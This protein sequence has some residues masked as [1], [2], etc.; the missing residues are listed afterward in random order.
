M[1]KP[2]LN[3]DLGEGTNNEALIMPLINSCSIACTGHVG[4]KHSMENAIV[5]AKQY[6]VHAGAHPSYPDPENFGRV[7]LEIS[8]KDLIGSI[9]QQ[10]KMLDSLLEKHNIPLNHIKAHGAL[11]NETAVNSNL[12]LSYLKAIEPYKFRSYLYL[13]Y[14]SVISTLAKKH[15]F[16]I[17]YEAFGDRSYRED[18]SLVSRDDPGAVIKDKVKVLEQIKS[19]Y[20]KD[21]VRTHNDNHVM[22]K[23]DTFC[24]HSYTQNAVSILSYLNEQ[25]KID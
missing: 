24:I 17:K 3:C 16:G 14:G 4:D 20:L 6:A 11:Y 7:H 13:P 12:A 1:L 5:I 9:R 18:L 23:A 15:G 10:I 22:L 19:I 21:R 2:A 8:D 25:F